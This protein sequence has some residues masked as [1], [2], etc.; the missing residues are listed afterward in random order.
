MRFCLLLAVSALFWF[1]GSHLFSQV[2]PFREYTVADGLPQSQTTDIYQ[3]SR[4]FLWITSRNGVSCF[5][6]I[7]F[8][9]YFRKD[10]L[11]GNMVNQVTENAEGVIYAV[12][13]DGVSIFDGIKFSF[14]QLPDKY[15]NYKVQ[16]GFQADSFLIFCY[17]PA[18]GRQVLLS[19]ENGSYNKYSENIPAIDSIDIMQVL[20]NQNDKEFVILSTGERV[21]SYKNEKLARFPGKGYRSISWYMNKI[22]LQNKAGRF[23]YK[24]GRM[25]PFVNDQLLPGPVLPSEEGNNSIF[26]LVNRNDEFNIKIQRGSVTGGLM[27]SN[28]TLWLSG[29]KNLYRLVSRA[30][31]RISFESLPESSIWSL[32]IDKN[33]KLW[34]GSLYGDLQVFNGSTFNRRNEYK[35]L[36]PPKTGF[37]KG[38]RM[39]S[40]GDIY[41]A[42]NTGVLI[43]DGKSFSRMKNIPENA[44]VCYIYEDPV[45]K[46]VLLGTGIGLYR[47]KDGKVRF[48]P[49][50]NDDRYGVIEGIVRDSTD[51]YWLSGHK[52][53]V[54]FDICKNIHHADTLWP[55]TMTYTL[56]KDPHGG[57][58]V[59]S[60][61]GLFFKAK[62]SEDFVLALPRSSNRPANSIMLMDSVNLL[63]GRSGDLCIINL[64]KFY[65][66][67]TGFSRIYD[68]TDGF[69]GD[70]CLDNGIIRDRRGNFYILS[71]DGLDIL[72]PD[73][74]NINKIPPKINLLSVE[75]AS[76]SNTW[77]QVN[78]PG[79]FYGQPEEIVLKRDQKR[80]RVRYVGI[81][82]VNP[83]KVT[84]QCRLIG[85]DDIWK[86][87]N[88]ARSAVYEKLP[89][90][91]YRFELKAF[92][93]DGVSDTKT[94]PVVFNVKPALWQ[95][96][97]F[98]IMLVFI[99]LGASAFITI[100]IMKE[101]H[102][103]KVEKEK[104]QSRLSQLYLASALKQ[105]DPHFTFNVLSSVGSLIMSSEKETAYEYLLKLSGL[106]R[107]V[108]NDGNAIIKPLSE[109][110]DFVNKYCEV[111]KLR[112]G[113][114][115]D[116]K[117]DIG[118]GVDLNRE[119]PKMT[120]QIFVE[121]AIKHGLEN[122]KDGGKLDIR[123]KKTRSG[124]DIIIL[125]NGVGR[126]AAARKKRGGSGNGIRIIGE[127]FEQMNTRNINNAVIEISDLKDEN[128]PLGTEVKISIPHDYDFGI[129]NT[130]EDLQYGKETQI[131]NFRG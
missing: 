129:S 27:D 95:R 8:K 49:E 78:K 85:Y 94:F 118:P 73:Y 72:D 61:E 39:M 71:S 88:Y 45:D 31:R 81:S 86:S 66:K 55:Q 38:S 41:F 6:G 115:I 63:V 14:H 83:E 128:I 65:K 11:P 21:Y 112:F 64:E 107:S 87:R 92:N 130:D 34:I 24:N 97:S 68:K 7:E 44:Q 47:L 82:T 108:L 69:S 42:L 25:K 79:L 2:Y 46:S 101:I 9:S 104:L 90:G 80:L 57:L 4:G 35:S 18:R 119:I 111:Q 98:R 5:D 16:T 53:M 77:V 91:Q 123:L 22:N 62:N 12:S 74:L 100:L 32:A 26:R 1:Q 15:R 89:P 96:F 102:R 43:W 36:F 106:L 40:N 93:A 99:L 54:L 19:F 33:G 37:Y 29:E 122:K 75:V 60:D 30:F 10:G 109:E 120:I 20:Y 28:L 116:W 113:N 124:L 84:Y 50:F 23:E 52:G 48:F 114:R 59:T 117:I 3:D 70:D 17:N 56:E 51:R 76:D 58:W 121:N 103:K 110:I 127:L 126:E 67:Q 125:D 13:N 131:G 105:F